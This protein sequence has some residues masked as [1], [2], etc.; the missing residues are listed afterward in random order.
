M[1]ISQAFLSDWK[2]YIT[3]MNIANAEGMT[4]CCPIALFLAPWSAKRYNAINSRDL[5]IRTEIKTDCSGTFYLIS[6]MRLSN[7]DS[8]NQKRH[9]VSIT[10]II[11]DRSVSRKFMARPAETAVASLLV[12]KLP[13]VRYGGKWSLKTNSHIPCRSPAMQCC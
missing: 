2:H 4:D 5:F 12:D 10:L 3:R 9:K 6:L 11:I 13:Y 8:E 1:S 7:V